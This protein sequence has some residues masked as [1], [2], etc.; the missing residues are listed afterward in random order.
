VANL[1]SNLNNAKRITDLFIS[2]VTNTGGTRNE[3]MKRS[4]DFSKEM[5]SYI[6]QID[7]MKI[8]RFQLTTDSKPVF[9]PS[10][11]ERIKDSGFRI[12][13]IQKN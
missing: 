12:R 7:L 2:Y 10:D 5:N 11:S 8:K 9:L 6:R 3:T 4:L 13:V 1:G